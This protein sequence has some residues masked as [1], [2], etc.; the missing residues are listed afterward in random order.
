MNIL[1]MLWSKTAG[2]LVMVASLLAAL[3]GVRYS[4][5]KGAKE[6]MSNE[7]KERTLERVNTA[8]EVSR[9]VDGLSDDAILD[10]LRDNGWLRD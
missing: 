9:D 7:I 3:L 4:I 2:T 1:A 10:K 6:E 5:R 8:N